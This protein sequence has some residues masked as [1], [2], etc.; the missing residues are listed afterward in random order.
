MIYKLGKIY[1]VPVFETPVGFKFLGPAMTEHNALIA[2]E[3][4]GGYAFRNHI[5]ERDGIL[6]GLYL[7]D[8]MARTGKTPSNLLRELEHMVGTHRYDR[9][10]I[11]FRSEFV[12]KIKRRV[13][14]AKPESI[15][16]IPVISR[17]TIDGT[18][19][20]LEDGSWTLIRF[21]GTEPLLRIYA[22]AP[23]DAQVSTLIASAQD[24]TGV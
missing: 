7:L 15:A 22:E 4:S 8:L 17:D 11:F 24:I 12:E 14:S 19:F 2:G 13:E 23:S 20:R 5:P 21:S 9:K 1:K 3:E 16:G 6:S 10:D 18:R